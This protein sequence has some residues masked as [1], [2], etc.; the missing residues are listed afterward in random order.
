MKFIS[1]WIEL[2]NVIPSEVT[3]T[4]KEKYGIYLFICG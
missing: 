3:Q 1:K 2:K 4:Q